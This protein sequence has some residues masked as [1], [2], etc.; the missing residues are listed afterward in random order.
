MR[1]DAFPQ[2]IVTDKDSTLMNAVKTVFHESTNLLC[3]FYIDKNIKAKCK[4][5]MGQKHAWD[6]VME[7]WVSL[8][9][10][11]TEI[12]YD[13]CLTKFEIACSP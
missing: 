7:A 8:V 13:D 6:Y 10:C 5:L 12:E 1:S 11:S 9:N 3:R 4:T 2:V